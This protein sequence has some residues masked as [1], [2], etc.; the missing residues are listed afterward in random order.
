MKGFKVS[1]NVYAESAAEALE[2]ENAIK[3]FISSQ[4]QEGRAV[5]ARKIAEA[6]GK[7]KDNYFVNSYFR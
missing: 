6:I 1:F 7:Y 4:A 5:T 2:A 3:A